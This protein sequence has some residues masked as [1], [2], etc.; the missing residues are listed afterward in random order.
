MFRTEFQKN[1][2]YFSL[3]G[4]HTFGVAS[5]FAL[6]RPKTFWI[7]FLIVR[8]FRIIRSEFCRFEL[9]DADCT[10]YASAETGKITTGSDIKNTL[11]PTLGVKSAVG[12]VL[13]DIW[14]CLGV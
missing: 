13:F 11:L 14:S 12:V 8:V 5:S 4:I 9:R 2:A 7:Y 10:S 3:Q 1:P 6:W